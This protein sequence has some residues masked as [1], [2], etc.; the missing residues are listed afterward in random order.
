MQILYFI[1]S[2]YLIQQWKKEEKHIYIHD[3]ELKL[4]GS[5]TR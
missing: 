5:K 1:S 4:S 2:S 3:E